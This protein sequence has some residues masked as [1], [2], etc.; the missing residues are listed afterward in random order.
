MT[1]SATSRLK[2]AFRD[3]N[4]ATDEHMPV[5]FTLSKNAETG[6]VTIR[7]SEPRASP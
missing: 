3:R 7:Y 1:Q 4:I 6:V 2:D 5:V